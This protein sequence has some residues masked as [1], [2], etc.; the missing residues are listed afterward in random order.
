MLK[1]KT[2]KCIGKIQK[3]TIQVLLFAFPIKAT[4][5]KNIVSGPAARCVYNCR[6]GTFFFILPPKKSFGQKK[7]K[8]FAA[9]R[10]ATISATR[11]TGN[12][13]FFKGG[14]RYTCLKECPANSTN[15]SDVSTVNTENILQISTC[16]ACMK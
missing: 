15:N 10:L 13:L 14:L 9:A 12:K 6:M 5:K 16:G 2:C 7:K 3:E 1:T 4:L 11:W 8:D